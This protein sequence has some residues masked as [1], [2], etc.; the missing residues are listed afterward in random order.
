[1]MN[2][3]MKAAIQAAVKDLDAIDHNDVGDAHEAADDV[4]MG[5]LLQVGMTE[6]VEAYERLVERC[7]SWYYV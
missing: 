3:E 5:V 7:G 1:M 4:V 6:I 2:D